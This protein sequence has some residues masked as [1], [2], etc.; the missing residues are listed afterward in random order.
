[1]TCNADCVFCSSKFRAAEFPGLPEAMAIDADFDVVLQRLASEPVLKYEITGGGEPF[2]NRHL[3]A[4]VHGIRAALPSA[5]IKVYTNGHIFRRL[6]GI[7]ELNISVAHWDTSV[8]NAIFRVHTPKSILSILDFF[9]PERT[10]KLR[11]SI[12][13]IRGGIDDPSKAREM[14]DRTWPRVDGYVLRPLFSFTP[15]RADY[16]GEFHIDDPRVELDYGA[17]G[18]DNILLWMPNN[19]AYTSW[20]L[21]EGLSRGPT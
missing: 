11:L 19:R 6:D 10:Y 17:C 12:P 14:I 8:N 1:M 4:I 21:A 15:E 3:Q 2:L 9:S 16:D 13:M 20:N 7:D 18:H 5:H